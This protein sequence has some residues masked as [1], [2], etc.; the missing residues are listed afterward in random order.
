[1]KVITFANNK[2]GTGKTTTTTIIAHGLTIMLQAVNAPNQ[3]VLVVDTDSQAH[4]TLLLAGRKDFVDNLSLAGVLATENKD[5]DVASIL[6]R[7]VIRSKWD[8]KL[9][10]LPANTSLDAIEES[11]VGR[12]GNVFYLRRVLKHLAPHYAAILIDTCP[13]FSLLTKMALLA[14]DE[15]IIPVAPQYLDV[16]GLMSMVNR[17]YEIR[18]RW[19]QDKPDITGIVVVKFNAAI[20]GHNEMQ[21]TVTQHPHLGAL[22]LGTVPLNADIEYSH[23]HRQSVFEYNSRSK[24]AEAY[25]Q[26][27]RTIGQPLLTEV[28]YVKE[29]DK[30]RRV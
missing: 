26:I 1:M 6:E 10:V 16:D 19:E 9:H 18:Y 17:V 22:Y 3:N 20:N 21:A 7:A 13:K 25:A 2:G 30:R 11:M 12:D 5:S 15:V 29:T 8:D 4:S 28:Y 24:G 23:S 14:S 27:T